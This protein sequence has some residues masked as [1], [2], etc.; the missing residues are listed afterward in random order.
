M[1]ELLDK[2]DMEDSGFIRD[3]AHNQLVVD[4]SI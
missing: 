2:M 1:L 3:G 4:K